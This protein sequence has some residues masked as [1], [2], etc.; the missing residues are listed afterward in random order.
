[1]KIN[2]DIYTLPTS[3]SGVPILP[4]NVPNLLP[5]QSSEAIGS[6]VDCPDVNS[7]DKKRRSHV[8]AERAESKGFQLC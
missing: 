2:V 5:I 1:M 4:V 7:V 6:T 8:V 3:P